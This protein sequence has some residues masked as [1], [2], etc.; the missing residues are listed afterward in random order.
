MGGILVLNSGSSSIKF[1][2]FDE[3]LDETLSGSATEIGGA[4]DLKISSKDL[5]TK[6]A[7]ADLPDHAAALRA[8]LNTVQTEGVDIANLAG[9]GHRV[10]HG[11][12]VLQAAIRVDGQ[13]IAEIERCSDLAPLHNPHN[14]AAIMA[15]RDLAPDLVQVACFDTAFHASNPEVARRYALPDRPEMETLRRYG[16]HGISYQGLIKKLADVSES[17][18]PNR[19]LAFHL[20]NGASL[21]AIKSGQSVATTMGYSPLEGLTMGTR[22]GNID[23]NLVLRLAEENGIED[24]KELLN[25]KSGLLGLGGLSD[26]RALHAAETDASRFA[27]EH[28]CYW[29]VRHAGSMIAAMGGLDGIAFTGGIGENDA[30]VRQKIISGLRFLG[31]TCDPQ[32]NDSN[33]SRIDVSG[34]T[35]PIWIAKAEEEKTIAAETQK[36]IA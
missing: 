31:A 7:S 25:K 33:R 4:S 16:F 12:S 14:L 5:V 24:T 23:G 28:F 21:C 1:A 10:V 18:V 34:S 29:A 2:L 9:A 35:V 13:V 15:L 22:T 20:G 6:E 11:G 3:S 17:G 30:V 8:I 26:M 19:L 36:L 32:S 27:V